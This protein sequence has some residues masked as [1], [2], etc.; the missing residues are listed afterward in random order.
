MARKG[1]ERFEPRL[2]LRLAVDILAQ[3]VEHQVI[4]DAPRTGL[5]YFGR[6]VHVAQHTVVA[7]GEKVGVHVREVL[8]AAIKELCIVAHTAEC[9]G[10]GGEYARLG[11]HFHHTRVGK[12]GIARESADRAAVGAETV[13]VTL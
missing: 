3:L 10:N 4:A 13:G 2:I 12:S 11:G 5:A 7:R 6:K 9:A 8:V 1:K